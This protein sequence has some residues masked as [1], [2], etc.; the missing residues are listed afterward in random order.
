MTIDEHLKVLEACLEEWGKAAG[1][2]VRVAG[3][4]VTALDM[5]RSRPGVASGV[6][7]F[8]E[9]TPA[10]DWDD[11]GKVERKFKVILSRGRGFNVNAG[12]SI[13]AGTGGGKAMSVLI[14]EAREKLRGLRLDE[15]DPEDQAPGYLGTG[16]FQVQGFVL[17]AY[18]IRMVLRTNIPRVEG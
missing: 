5:L 11:L 16:Q 4:E 12:E 18:E 15:P 7:V 14:E 17:D 9:E 1:C 10:T 2:V 8:N 13:T 6:I 3:D